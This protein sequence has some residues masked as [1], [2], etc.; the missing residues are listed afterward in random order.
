MFVIFNM[1][2]FYQYIVIVLILSDSNRVF[3][4]AYISVFVLFVM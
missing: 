1:Y 3:L 2:Q 4:S